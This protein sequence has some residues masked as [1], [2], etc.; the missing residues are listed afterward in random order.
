MDRIDIKY[1]NYCKRS[2][3]IAAKSKRF[4]PNMNT[5]TNT[6]HTMTTSASRRL[7]TQGAIKM[8]KQVE[9]KNDSQSCPSRWPVNTKQTQNVSTVTTANVNNSKLSNS[10]MKT[11]NIRN[12]ILVGLGLMTVVLLGMALVD[13]KGLPVAGDYVGY[14]AALAILALGAMDNAGAKKLN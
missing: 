6:K 11:N 14:A 4:L 8:G 9:R 2:G 7:A 13:A 12:F 1:F 5:T 10:S 3:M